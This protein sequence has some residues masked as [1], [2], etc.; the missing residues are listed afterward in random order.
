VWGHD[1]SRSRQRWIGR[2]VMGQNLAL[3]MAEHEDTL[4]GLVGRPPR[5][6]SSSLGNSLWNATCADLEGHPKEAYTSSAAGVTIPCMS[7]AGA[8]RRS[9]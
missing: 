6:P 2:A 3:N 5:Y 9:Q 7:R 1:D 8:V 4:G